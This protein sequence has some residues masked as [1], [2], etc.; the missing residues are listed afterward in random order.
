MNPRRLPVAAA[1]LLGCVAVVVVAAMGAPA[2]M[3]DWSGQWENVG[4]TPDASGG[5]NQSLDDVLKK[6]QWGP[7]NKPELQARV[8]KIQAS[9]RKRLDTI[10]RGDDAGGEE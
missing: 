6:M 10:A 2:G 9:E 5:F 1:I 3:P 4:A 8:D 7:P